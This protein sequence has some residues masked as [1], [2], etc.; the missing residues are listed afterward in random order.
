M[1]NKVSLTIFTVLPILAGTIETRASIGHLF[2]DGWPDHANFH[3]LM[4]L[5]GLLAAY[6]L[7]LAL[8]WGP[9][10][11]GERWSWYAVAYTVLMV[12]GGQLIS[13]VVTNGGLRNQDPIAAS[14]PV[15]VGALLVIISLYVI[16]LS[17]SW[18]HTRRS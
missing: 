14:G 8:A 3:M 4:G 10:R 1:V 9:L 13:D 17:L 12:H 16:G 6:G 15:I 18:R 2:G 11:R 7:V 5:G